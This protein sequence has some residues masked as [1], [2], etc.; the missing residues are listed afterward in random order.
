MQREDLTLSL[1]EVRV[2][3]EMRNDSAGPVTLR[4]AFPLPELP[5]LTPGG[6]ITTTGGYNIPMREPREANFIDFR[7]WTDGRELTPEVEIRATLPD[8]RDVAA[9][10]R[11]IGGIPLVMRSGLFFPPD[12][13][14]LDAEARRRLTETGAIE[15]LDGRGY[16]LPWTTYVTFHWMQ[17]FAPGVTVVEHSYRPIVGFLPFRPDAQG[18]VSGTDDL[19]A[20]FCIDAAEKRRLHDISAR[21]RERRLKAGEGENSYLSGYTLGYVL[22]TARNWRGP[23]GTFHLTVKDDPLAADDVMASKPIIAAYLC[24]QTPLG[25]TGLEPC[26]WK[27]RPRTSCPTGICE[28]CSSRNRSRQG[29]L[30]WPKAN[31]SPSSSAPRRNG[32]RM[33]ATPGWPTA[34]RWTTAICR[35]ASAGASAARLP[36]SSPRRASSSS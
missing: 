17:T 5:A 34:R 27:A 8:G 32:R 20:T 14:D 12:D 31:R 19:A 16:R 2:R 26:V 10:V 36:R 22:Q 9:A 1:N 28:S 4:V 35:S 11:Q 24:S 7:V 25:Q 3:Y 15:L 6:R 23:I 18:V 29:R 30:S 13:A 21:A 33:G